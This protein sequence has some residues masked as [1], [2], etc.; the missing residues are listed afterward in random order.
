MQDDD[1]TDDRCN[2]LKQE[3]DHAESNA[4][5]QNIC[6][7]SIKE[8]IQQFN[9]QLFLKHQNNKP[10]HRKVLVSFDLHSVAP[11]SRSSLVSGIATKDRTKQET[12]NTE[13]DDDADAS[14]NGEI[15]I[16]RH[17]FK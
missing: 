5:G 7:N 15:S 9:K 14:P 2:E 12:Y 3:S 10:S 16:K 4:D 8:Y 17:I 1:G 11:R 6:N 13:D